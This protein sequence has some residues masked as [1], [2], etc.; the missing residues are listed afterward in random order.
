MTNR[1]TQFAFGLNALAVLRGIRGGPSE[2][3]RASKRAFAAA[4]EVPVVSAYD[5]PEISLGEI[6]GVRKPVIKLAV[7]RYEDGMLPSDQAMALLAILVAEHP[8]TVLE[9][10]T[11]MGHT[12]RQMAENLPSAI[13][14][15]VDLPESFGADDN[16]PGEMPKDDF[17]LIKARR[18]GQE[19]R[20]TP[21]AARIR[22]HFG[23]T[24]T[25]DFTTAGK[26]T[27][28][29]IDGSHT[30]EYCKSDSQKAY[31]A[32]G[33]KGV[34]LWHDCDVVHP[35]VERFVSEWRVLG[36]DIRRI[37]GTPLAYWKST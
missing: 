25:W 5:I 15:T 2:V 11:F 31:A 10:G 22:Q 19:F 23:D 7:A 14:N 12:T 8:S 13:I 33:G 6:L 34:F 24:A 28:F 20:D 1:F 18:V 4:A 26:P 21:E 37:A 35:G 16:V 27:F 29:F 17:H 30:Y 32:C 9:I 3:A 36:R